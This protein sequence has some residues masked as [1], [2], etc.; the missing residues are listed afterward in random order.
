MHRT[1]KTNFTNSELA[2]RCGCGLLPTDDAV[3]ALQNLRRVCGFPFVINSGARCEKHNASVKGAKG[4]YHVE[5]IA[6]DIKCV[7]AEK[8]ALLVREAMNCGFNGVGVYNDFIHVDLRD[9]P[10]LWRG[11][12]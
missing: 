4:S 9:E 11:K 7:D 12:Y 8:R 5:R 6:F 2:C 3:I 1:L 10:T